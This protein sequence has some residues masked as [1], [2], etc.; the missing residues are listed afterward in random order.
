MLKTVNLK[1]FG[2]KHKGKVRDYYI[3]GNKRILI[4]TD[5]ISAFDVILGYIPD[6]GQVLNLLSQFWFEK[7]RDIVKNHMVSVPHPN[8][9]IGLNAQ[10][11][12]IEM[13]VRGYITGV[14][15]TSIWGSY[16]KGERIIY[17][18]KFPNGLKKNQKLAKPVITPTTKEEVGHDARLTRDEI[19]N[20][21]I[22]PEKIYKQ[23]EQVALKLFDR[24]TRICNKAGII[25][26]DTKYEFGMLN[27]KLILIDE[28]HTPD[29]SRF[30][31]KKTYKT[32][33]KKGLEPENFDKE[34]LRI[35]YKEKG[36]TG[37]GAPPQMTKEFIKQVSTRYI[38]IYEKLTGKK[39]V[40]TRADIGKS[41]T[42]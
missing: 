39:F 40:V 42:F 14:T 37:T 18:I 15:N 30:W 9:M 2:K 16:A 32:R 27:G 7:T 24:G 11:I 29:S 23:M 21:K 19:I 12:S 4:T 8:V 38:A 28:I 26:V 25:L 1:G 31:I 17:G 36:Y 34:F 35:W 10:P 13:V 20:K 5:R 6:K 41:I 22:I 33:F 3:V